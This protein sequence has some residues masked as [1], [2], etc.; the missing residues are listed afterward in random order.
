MFDM[1]QNRVIVKMKHLEV[2]FVT[3]ANEVDI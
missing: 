1:I 2:K 3:V